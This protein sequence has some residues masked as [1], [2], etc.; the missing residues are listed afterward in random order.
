[1]A[2][3][4]DIPDFPDD[5]N[6][7]GDR[8]APQLP[9]SLRDAALGLTPQQAIFVRIV[10]EKGDAMV[11][12][13]QAKLP[14]PENLAFEELIRS[15]LDD[16]RV[17]QALVQGQQAQQQVQTIADQVPIRITKEALESRLTG[18]MDRAAAASAFGAEIAAVKVAA[19][20]NGLLKQEINVNLRRTVDE[21]SDREL[22]RIARGGKNV[23]DAEFTE[24]KNG[25]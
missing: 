2:D 12:A 16:P 17:Q 8:P 5:P 10:L 19:S 25:D 1:M 24:E 4:P 6:F 7:D 20:L 11:A 22:E 13:V 14:N 23:I 9:A 18:I 3:T 21:M 15:T